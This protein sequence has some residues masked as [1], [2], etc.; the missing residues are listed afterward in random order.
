MAIAERHL[1]KPQG[2]FKKTEGLLKHG[3]G[4]IAAVG[5]GITL[6]LGGI[7]YFSRNEAPKEETRGSVAE[8]TFPSW[9]TE[10]KPESISTVEV[11]INPLTLENGGFENFMAVSPD[12]G[13]FLNASNPT[14]SAIKPDLQTNSI[15]VAATFGGEKLTKENSGKLINNHI[16]IPSY[17]YEGLTIWYQFDENTAVYQKSAQDSESEVVEVGKGLDFVAKQLKLGSTL[18]SILT[19]SLEGTKLNLTEYQ[20]KMNANTFNLINSSVDSENSKRDRVFKLYS[21][22]IQIDI[23]K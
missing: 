12:K 7:S 13:S 3:K 20:I 9:Y 11:E 22:S 19:T 15:W 14:I 5:L 1:E 18:S 10:L 8:L 4:K 21:P 6:A 17:K 23:E 16:Y 2:S